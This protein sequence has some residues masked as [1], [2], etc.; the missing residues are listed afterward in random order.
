MRMPSDMQ[1]D[2]CR[3]GT[4]GIQ[5]HGGPGVTTPGYEGPGVA[6]PGYGGEGVV[7]RGGILRLHEEVSPRRHGDTE[8]AARWEMKFE[9]WHE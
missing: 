7:R 6:T 3:E 1:A 4:G 8:D 9:K 5:T 2:A